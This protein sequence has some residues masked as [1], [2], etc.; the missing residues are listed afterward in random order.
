MLSLADKKIEKLNEQV[1]AL[2]EE[3]E[4]LEEKVR[5]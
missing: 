1:R 4:N 3:K 5:I 2:Q